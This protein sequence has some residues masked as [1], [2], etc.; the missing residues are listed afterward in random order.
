MLRRKV[1]EIISLVFSA[2]LFSIYLLL[3]ILLTELRNGSN[4]MNLVQNAIIG[5][6]FLL[7]IPTLPIIYDSK[8]GVIDIYISQREKRHRYFLVA[9]GS[10]IVGSGVFYSLREITLY[11]F[12]TC[13]ATVTTSILLANTI[14][15]VSVH[16]AGIAGPVTFMVLMYGVQFS[17]LYFL[18]IPIGWS[19]YIAQAHTKK[20]L[21]A[22]ALIAIL[23]TYLTILLLR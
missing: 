1:A 22:G 15:K 3:I 5:I 16:T 14:T 18:L 8:R 4:I 13:Y 11:L 9:I 23:V 17:V 2:P 10:Y 12:L 6:V 21:I 19:R 7:I 20:Q